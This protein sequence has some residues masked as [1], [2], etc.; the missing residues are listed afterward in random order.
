MNIKRVPFGTY[1]MAKYKVKT[2]SNTL[3]AQS[4]TAIA[5]RRSNESGGFY[6]MNLYTWKRINAYQWHVLPLHDEII[7]RVEAM[8]EEEGQPLM[9]DGFPIFEWKPGHTAVDDTEDITDMQ[10]IQESLDEQPQVRQTSNDNAQEEVIHE[11]IDEEEAVQEQNLN[12]QQEDVQQNGVIDVAQEELDGQD[13]NLANQV[14]EQ[15]MH[16]NVAI[17]EDDDSINMIEDD[18]N[19]HENYNEDFVRHRDPNMQHRGGNE[20]MYITDNES[21]TYEDVDYAYDEDI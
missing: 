11:E 19:E 7:E 8:G 20:Y 14:D 16:N 3:V 2:K 9:Q 17:I 12:N 5:L 15:A 13:H 1:A 18:I 21:S 10:H 6:F 4:V